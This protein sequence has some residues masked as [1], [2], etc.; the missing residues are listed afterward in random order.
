MD[1][2]EGFYDYVT[3]TWR[4]GDV[5]FDSVLW[6]YYDFKSLRTNN[7]VEGWHHR[8]NNVVYLHF[9]FIYSCNSK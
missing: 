2:Y 1:E 3:N 4:V 5:S 8:L 6:S 9:L 7:Y